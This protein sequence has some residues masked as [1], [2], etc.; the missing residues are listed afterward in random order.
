MSLPAKSRI[1][2][3]VNCPPPRGPIDTLCFKHARPVVRIAIHSWNL[4]ARVR[5][6][7]DEVGPDRNA[8]DFS[9][10]E[11]HPIASFDFV[12]HESPVGDPVHANTR[13]SVPRDPRDDGFAPYVVATPSPTEKGPELC[14]DEAG[15]PEGGCRNEVCGKPGVQGTSRED[16]SDVREASH[17]D[18][19]A[20]NGADKGDPSPPHAFR[21]VAHH[22][23]S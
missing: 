5:P 7:G 22:F 23:A 14:D 4:K 18:A 16:E 1:V 21:P 10:L 15:K 17:C 6:H 8:I 3:S 2:G 12:P 19:S 13:V 11:E 20:E 9:P